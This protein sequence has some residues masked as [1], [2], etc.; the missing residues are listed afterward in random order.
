MHD[1]LI[2]DVYYFVNLSSMEKSRMYRGLI[3]LFSTLTRDIYMGSEHTS[4]K[5]RQTEN[6]DSFKLLAWLC[7]FVAPY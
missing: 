2:Y 5:S 1:T 3:I 4:L 6:I 7:E